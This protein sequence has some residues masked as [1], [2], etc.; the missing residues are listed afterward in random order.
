MFCVKSAFAG[1]VVLALSPALGEGAELSRAPAHRTRATNE[2]MVRLI[3]GGQLHLTADVLDQLVRKS[4]DQHVPVKDVL[5]GIP[6]TGRARLTG[7]TRLELVENSA[8]GVFDVLL[9]GKAVSSTIG[10]AGQ[11]KIHSGTVT[12]FA[13][14]KRVILDERGL[15]ALPAACR[16][17]ATST[18][19]DATSSLPGMRG[20]IG[21]ASCWERV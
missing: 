17:T 15:T 14:R 13:A 5:L 8:R 20:Q 2:A 1:L 19:T 7:N 16:A 21:R 12:Q 4:I 3:E 9:T 10:D 6:L 11:A 18:L